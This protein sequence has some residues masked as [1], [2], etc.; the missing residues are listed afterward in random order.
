MKNSTPHQWRWT[1][2]FLLAAALA[3]GSAACRVPLKTPP[4][5]MDGAVPQIN[6][7]RLSEFATAAGAVYD[8]SAAIAARYGD[9]N[10]VVRDLPNTDG[11]YFIYFDHDRKIQT[12]AVRGTTNE[13]NIWTDVDTVKVPDTALGIF[14]HRGFKIATDD[15]YADIG[16]FLQ[17][18]YKTRIT[19][20]SLG[21]AM[22]AILMMYLVKDGYSVEEVLTFGQPKVTNEAGGAGVTT[23]YFRVINDQDVVAQIPPSNL[24]FDLSGPYQHFGPE[25]TLMPDKTFTYSPA[26]IPRDLIS[27]TLWK[28]VKPA[29]V[30]DHRIQSYIDRLNALK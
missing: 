19:G 3:L 20:H 28:T 11:R 21:G 7:A 9:K 26:H 30:A 29:D 27:G 5:Q 10:V 23:P 24:V 6:W 1:A 25:I 15:L 22:A 17:R 4:I 2:S 12:I 18:D 8:S 13:A 14:L 16:P